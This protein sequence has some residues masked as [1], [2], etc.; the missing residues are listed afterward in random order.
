MP[1]PHP[2]V[3]QLAARRLSLG[4]T[5]HDLAMR[6][7]VSQNAVSQWETGRSDLPL[8]R[9]LAYAAAVGLRVELRPG[10][11]VEVQAA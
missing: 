9:L 11:P 6:I 8:V 5:Q 10:R 3:S 7:G 2:L 4:W 1:Y